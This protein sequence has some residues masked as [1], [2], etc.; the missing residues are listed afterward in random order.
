MAA[1]AKFTR[2]IVTG[3]TESHGQ[4]INALADQWEVSVAAIIRE[5]LDIALPKL[6]ARAAK[7]LTADD[8]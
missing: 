1:I 8:H 4:R 7:D 3:V 6:E 2:Q 5:S